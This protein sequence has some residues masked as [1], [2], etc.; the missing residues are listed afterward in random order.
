M[1]CFV[2]V[3]AAVISVPFSIFAQ[4]VMKAWNGVTPIHST[5]IDV[6]KIYGKAKETKKGIFYQS[7]YESGGETL[8]VTYSKGRCGEV[9]DSAWNLPFDTVVWFSV[10]PSTRLDLNK[11][12]EYFNTRFISF[13]DPH[14]PTQVNYVSE[15]GAIRTT[16]IRSGNGKEKFNGFSFYPTKAEEKQFL[17]VSK[18]IPSMLTGPRASVSA[19]YKISLRITKHRRPS[20]CPS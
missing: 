20:S 3:L 14:I 10:S 16:S 2:M 12:I 13:N 9:N 8:T 4:D 15:D 19:R 17:C 6:E 5:R 7:L 11:L 1:K 18:E